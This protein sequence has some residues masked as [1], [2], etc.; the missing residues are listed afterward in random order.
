[1]HFRDY[2]GRLIVCCLLFH[3]KNRGGHFQDIQDKKEKSQNNYT[4]EY[5]DI[6][7]INLCIMFNDDYQKGA[8]KDD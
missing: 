2:G 7:K 6:S 1:M 3:H 5:Y 4:D 8:S